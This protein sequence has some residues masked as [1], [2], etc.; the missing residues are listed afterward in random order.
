MEGKRLKVS[1]C[2]SVC[3]LCR[4]ASRSPPSPPS[5]PSSSLMLAS[6]P[7]PRLLLPL[8]CL[9]LRVSASL[10][11]LV[12]LVVLVFRGRYQISPSLARSARRSDVFCLP[13]SSAFARAA[14]GSRQRSREAGK[15]CASVQSPPLCTFALSLSLAFPSCVLSTSVTHAHISDESAR[16]IQPHT[17]SHSHTRT[18]SERGREGGESVSVRNKV[19]Q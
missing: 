4:L 12:L 1:A 13:P 7:I 10:L 5:P 18:A 9:L 6:C 17:N 8:P 15:G 2:T 3:L 19:P 14:A 11:S 16:D